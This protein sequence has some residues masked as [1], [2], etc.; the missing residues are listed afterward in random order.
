MEPREFDSLAKIARKR[1]TSLSNMIREA[2]RDRYLS[3]DE[4]ARRS[5]SVQ[6]FLSLP[7]APLPEWKIVKKEL[8]ERRGK[9]FS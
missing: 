6:S 1:G 8:E 7:D 9:S 4:R 2:A 3:D 5:R